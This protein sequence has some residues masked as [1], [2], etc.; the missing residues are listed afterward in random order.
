MNQENRKYPRFCPNDLTASISIE[1]PPPGEKLTLE[2]TVINMSHA[3]IKIKLN[4]P[5]DI[6]IQ[7]SALLIN[8]TLPESGVPVTIRGM[9]RHLNNDSEYG[10]EYSERFQKSEA[11]KLMFECIK[12]SDNNSQK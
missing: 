3:G 6:D 4:T 1:P 9:I 10:F 7:K 11:D 2:G 12:V 8:L 5:V